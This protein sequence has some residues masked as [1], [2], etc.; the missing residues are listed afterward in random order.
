MIGWSPG[1]DAKYTTQLGKPLTAQEREQAEVEKRAEM[2]VVTDL[3][4]PADSYSWS[5]DAL[6][7]QFT[8]SD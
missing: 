7:G 6:A 1:K 2:I 4:E 3:P 5:I 8:V